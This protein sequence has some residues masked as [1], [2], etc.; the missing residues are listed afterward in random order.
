MPTREDEILNCLKDLIFING[1][2]ATELIT[3]VEN[4]SK[5]ARKSDSVPESCR[6]AHDRLNEQVIQIMEKY[7]S[8]ELTN[9][10]EHVRKH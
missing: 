10:K 3:L 8:S 5:I 4:S 9:L 7:W 2:I 6:Q 1:L